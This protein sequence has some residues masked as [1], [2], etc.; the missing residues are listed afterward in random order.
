M[1]LSTPSPTLVI[2]PGSLSLSL[3]QG[4][5]GNLADV[6]QGQCCGPCANGYLLSSYSR[7]GLASVQVLAAIVAS[8]HATSAL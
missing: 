6:P 2:A 3:V 7:A 1:Q 8:L 4:L 5:L